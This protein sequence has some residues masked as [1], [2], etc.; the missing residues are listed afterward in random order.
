MKRN[1]EKSVQ[2]RKKSKREEV[3]KV[4]E[5]EEVSQSSS[6]EQPMMASAV[7]TSSSSQDKPQSPFDSQFMKMACIVVFEVDPEANMANFIAKDSIKVDR[8]DHCAYL[9]YRDACSAAIFTPATAPGSKGTCERR[10]DIAEKCNATLNRDYYYKTTKPI[11]LQCFRCLPEKP[12]TKPSLEAITPQPETSLVT[13][14][15]HSSETTTVVQTE[16]SDGLV[17]T[18]LM[19]DVELKM[20]EMEPEEIEEKEKDVGITAFDVINKDIEMSTV[21][22]ESKDKFIQAEDTNSV[23]T[24]QAL[25]TFIGNEQT[26]ASIENI[27]FGPD[28]ETETFTKVISTSTEDIE[29]TTSESAIGLLTSDSTFE[30]HSATLKTESVLS[31]NHVTGVGAQTTFEHGSI[32]AAGSK[33]QALESVHQSSPKSEEFTSATT[34]ESSAWQKVTSEARASDDT[35]QREHEAEIGYDTTELT[36]ADGTGSKVGEAMTTPTIGTIEKGESEVEEFSSSVIMLSST[37]VGIDEFSVKP[38]VSSIK[39]KL[40]KGTEATRIFSEIKQATSE[41][42]TEAIY[43]GGSTEAKSSYPEEQDEATASSDLSTASYKSISAISKQK[44]KTD[45]LPSRDVTEAHIYLQGC[46]VTFQ[47]DPHS[48]RP[49]ESP[50]GFQASTI[51]QTVEVCAGRC[52]QDG[53]TGAKYDPLSKECILSYSGKQICNN[54]PEH[55]FYQANE[56]T[57]IHCT[58]CRMFILMS[59]TATLFSTEVPEVKSIKSDETPMTESG[60]ASETSTQEDEKSTE[61][62]IEKVMTETLLSS[63]S[64]STATA[65]VEEIST[66]TAKVSRA[67][68]EATFVNTLE[69]KTGIPEVQLSIDT[70][71]TSAA[72]IKGEELVSKEEIPI[73]AAPLQ[74]TLFGHDCSVLFQARPIDGHPKELITELIPVG[75][76]PTVKE[77]AKRCYMDGC[78]GA[79]FDPVNLECLLT[80]E[81]YH[82]CDENEQQHHSLEATETLWIHCI[83]CKKEFTESTLGLLVQDATTLPATDE[84]SLASEPT[85][86]EENFLTSVSPDIKLEWTEEVESAFA[87][88]SGKTADKS[89]DVLPEPSVGLKSTI[90]EGEEILFARPPSFGNESIFQVETKE[91]EVRSEESGEESSSASTVVAVE[92]EEE[93][94]RSP[95][96]KS[97]VE[98]S[99]KHLEMETTSTAADVM[100]TFIETSGDEL[101][102]IVQPDILISSTLQT[103]LNVPTDSSELSNISGEISESSVASSVVENSTTIPQTSTIESGE[104]KDQKKATVEFQEEAEPTAISAEITVM[105]TS[106]NGI[107]DDIVGAVA[108]IVANI[109]SNV[110]KTDMKEMTRMLEGSSTKTK[111]TVPFVALKTTVESRTEATSA[112]IDGTFHTDITSSI[113]EETASIKSDAGVTPEKVGDVPLSDMTKATTAEVVGEVMSVAEETSTSIS[114]EENTEA[115]LGLLEKTSDG[116]L[117]SKPVPNSIMKQPFVQENVGDIIKKIAQTKDIFVTDIKT[118][119]ADAA[120][121]EE[122][123]EKLEEESQVVSE[124]IKDSASVANKLGNGGELMTTEPPVQ[125]VSDLISVLSHNTKIEEVIGRKEK[126]NDAFVVDDVPVTKDVD[127]RM[128]TAGVVI[129]KLQKDIA[130]NSLQNIAKIKPFEGTPTECLGRIEFEILAIED[131]SQLNITNETAV[132][133]PAACAMKCYKAVN[134]LLAIYKESQN[135]EST[136][137]V[138]MLTSNSAICSSEKKF[139]PQH[140]S[141]LSPII[142]SCLKCTKCNYVISTMTELTRIQ[143]GETVEP[144]LSIGQ[145]GEI[146]WKHNCTVAQYDHKS[147]LC[148]LTSMKNQQ[149]CSQETPIVVN[150][151]EPVLLEC[152]RCFT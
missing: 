121:K 138:C 50:A 126:E 150:G 86:V 108:S 19:H 27:I 107:T 29:I 32:G 109:S 129:N 96:L 9:C 71:P 136:S 117:F 122:V 141:D 82:Q 98:L 132:E 110:P 92:E 17:K 33:I 118:V 28:V 49:A 22:E 44:K 78:T 47:A 13:Q 77:C 63:S 102:T 43:T 59:D 42:H 146:C 125:A 24:T 140:K 149:D 115:T 7:D 88:D 61:Q 70:I 31:T 40:S 1:D 101:E 116:V 54:G 52:Y 113:I 80:F 48:K 134:C 137:A 53:C 64:S 145:C 23:E 39:A 127:E 144:A 12:Q 73:T 55:F 143:Q 4:A 38:N 10:F 100:E 124:A 74:T 16:E 152:V 90:K 84:G 36:R 151:D 89:A 45:G 139:I 18:T 114:I 130:K 103:P 8:A 85:K 112:S 26:Q 20:A 68:E 69:K 81:D 72:A 14:K 123:V 95:T 62:A 57:W 67:T 128:M 104:R 15:K 83:S 25:I 75:A 51:A 135:D 79:K 105:P 2:L 111:G 131:L 120:V 37:G 5:S 133:S 35:L 93:I 87:S 119:V 34:E 94:S 142:I 148:L 3:G 11:H 58:G 56:T 30:S 6:S 21:V 76:T 97:S 46:I 60:V 147:N 106:I 41:G 65:V 91:Q 66:E 99:T